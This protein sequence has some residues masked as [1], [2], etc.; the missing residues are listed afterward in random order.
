MSFTDVMISPIACACSSRATE[1][2]GR[3]TR[4]ALGLAAFQETGFLKRPATSPSPC[5]P[6]RRCADADTALARSAACSRKSASLR[7]LSQ[8]FLRLRRAF[9]LPPA[10]CSVVAARI[11]ADPDAGK[12]YLVSRSGRVIAPFN[13]RAEITPTISARIPP[14]VNAARD[15]SAVVLPASAVLSAVVYARDRRQHETTNRVGG[16][17]DAR[18]YA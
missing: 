3:S 9:H 6:A 17:P 5:P 12:R 10:A 15:D 11:S 4:P 1:C 18:S 14:T 8:P 16:A 7:R 13:R 2:C